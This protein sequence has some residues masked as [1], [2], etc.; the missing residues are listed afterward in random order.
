MA[1]GQGSGRGR[2]IAFRDPRS[3]SLSKGFSHPPLTPLVAKVRALVYRPSMAEITI[4]PAVSDRFDDLELV[5]NGGGDGATCQC[6]WWMLVSKE[7]N[8]TSRDERERKLRD[9]VAAGPPPILLAY[10]DGVPA[11][12][13]RIG[14]RPTQVRLGRTRAYAQTANPDWSDDTVWA[15][16]CFVVRREFRGEGL[17]DRLLAAALEYARVGGARVVEAYPIDPSA[18]KKS[19]NDLSHGVLSTFTRAGFREVARPKP[20]T[21]I[22]ELVL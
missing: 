10:V 1:F 13:V 8:A 20:A 17:T 6:Q 4:E 22:V 18:E 16:T 21:A 7:F 15:M 5:L 12:L 19:A 14:P 11:A 2:S 3:L 9:E